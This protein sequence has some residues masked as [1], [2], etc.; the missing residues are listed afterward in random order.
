MRPSDSANYS[1]YESYLLQEAT[2]GSLVINFSN[3]VDLIEWRK[4]DN[5][6]GESLLFKDDNNE[7]EETPVLDANLTTDNN[8]YPHLK[9][10]IWLQLVHDTNAYLPNQLPPQLSNILIIAFLKRNSSSI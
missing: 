8:T 9:S 10:K 4:K 7:K 1:D 2:I 6:K 3:F 5:R